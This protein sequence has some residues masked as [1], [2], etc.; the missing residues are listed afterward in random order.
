MR[1]CASCGHRNSDSAKFCEECAAPLDGV[2]TQPSREQRKTVTVLFCD[3]TGSTALGESIDP[4]ALRALLARYFERMKQ[5]VE[6]HGGTVEKFVGDAVMAV[7][8]V[9]VVH[10]DDALRA[11][12]AA[13]EMRDALP[14]L[15]VQARIGLNTGEVVTGTEERL[16]T[17]D[18]VNVAARLEQAA[19][20]GEVLLGAATLALVAQS[21]EVEA[22]EPLALKG[23]GKPVPAYRLLALLDEAPRRAATSI[24]GRATEL[25]RLRDAFE[26]AAHDRSCQL[27]TILGAAGVGKSRL[28]AEFLDDLDATVVR[29][30]C[31]SYGEGITYWALVE[32]LLQL[33]TRPD[34][35][36]AAATI[37]SVLGE[38]VQATTPDEI[39]WAFRKT[40]EREA[41][42]RQVVCVFDDLHWAEPAF[43]DLVEHVADLS[44]DAPI[45]LLCNARPE[46]LDRRPGWGGGKL[47]ATTVLLEP[48]SP[49][50]TDELIDRL[51]ELDERLRS[52]IRDAAEGNPLFVEEML[53]MVRES[54]DVDVVA[55]PSIQALLAARLDQLDPAERVVLERGAVEGKVF[56]R[57]AVEALAPEERQAPERLLALV[58]K[59]LI[60]PDSSQIPGDDAFR[61]RHLLIRDAAYDGLPKAVRTDLHERFSLWLG[62]HGADLVELDEILG[63]HLEQAARYRAEL[64]APDAQLSKRAAARLLAAGRRAIAR[65]DTAAAVNLLSRSGDLLRPGSR[66]E[67]LIELALPLLLAGEFERLRATVDELKE[68][69]DPRSR[70]YGLVH[71]VELWQAV[72]P[73]LVVERGE[74]AA[75]EAEAVFTELEDERGLALAAQCRYYIE[76]MQSHSAAAHSAIQDMREHALRSGDS[77]IVLQSIRRGLVVLAFGYVPVDEGLREVERIAEAAGSG[78]L[79]RSLGLIVRGYLL[80]LQ[81]RFAESLE[82][83]A[84]GRELAAE[85]GQRVAWASYAHPTIVIRL[86]SG[87]AAG[88]A[89]DA[90]RSVDVLEELG[91]Q[92]YR[93][94]SLA[95]LALAL[96]AAGEPTEAEDAA[97]ESERI[98]APDDFIN[99]A[100]GRTARA[101][102]LA[103]RGDLDLAEK[104]ARSAVEYAFRT[105]FPLPKADALAALSR[106]LR[107]AGRADEAEEALSQAVALYEAK[108]AEACLGRL[109]EIAGAQPAS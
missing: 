98:S 24:V 83:M 79:A 97:F 54:G 27:F 60:R 29:G 87:D 71:E 14:E 35:E 37:A 88:A 52:R 99:F 61:F 31:L 62:E 23:K 13:A 39:A 81:G 85:L 20:P 66:D 69:T 5:I 6:R 26:Q 17:G 36:T 90:R 42:E 78:L 77:E 7:F 91:E 9:P 11:V 107:A 32:A 4:E 46:L 2:Q 103:D 55:P 30:R 15:G 19:P 33:E 3:V 72:E 8:G 48:L 47:N 94:T 1:T 18:A 82:R 43:L 44:R 59:E 40:L 108:G 92:G 106:V 41:A 101:L 50:E 73:S 100:M 56:H 58:R 89:E 84:K 102:V 51:G 76:W 10:E 95:Y 16:A 104:V 63:Y 96:Q 93:S 80:A 70:A 57:G 75:R 22:L 49:D 86:L 68:S 67:L 28:T 109:F 53:A 64:G 105:D 21:V 34:D 65:D 74:P 38:T 25:R 12:R 45:L